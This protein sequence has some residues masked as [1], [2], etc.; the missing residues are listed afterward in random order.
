MIVE[1]KQTESGRTPLPSTDKFRAGPHNLNE[2]IA[3]LLIG[4]CN[5]TASETQSCLALRSLLFAL[6]ATRQCFHFRG[7]PASTHG[8]WLGGSDEPNARHATSLALAHH[9]ARIAFLHHRHRQNLGCCA[10]TGNGR[11]HVAAH[12]N[13][14]PSPQFSATCRSTSCNRKFSLL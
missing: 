9:F 13:S 14:H 11:S 1:I 2:L 7:L 6:A 5:P 8:S 4:Y 10:S 12:W 3:H